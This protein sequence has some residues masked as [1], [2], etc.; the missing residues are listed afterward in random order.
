MDQRGVF[1][2]ELSSGTEVATFMQLITFS[3]RPRYSLLGNTVRI[4]EALQA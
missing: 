4:G 2:G 3:V 1:E